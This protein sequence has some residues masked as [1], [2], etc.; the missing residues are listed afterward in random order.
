MSLEQDPLTNRPDTDT[1]IPHS[2]VHGNE[3]PVT[4]F[5]NTSLEDV[6]DQ[7]ML[8]TPTS[9]EAL[10]STWVERQP[11]RKGFTKKQK[12]IA[13]ISGAAL[14]LGIGA[15]LKSMNNS[16]E[17]VAPVGPVATAASGETAT[18]TAEATKTPEIIAPA[19]KFSPEALAELTPAQLTERFT[20]KADTIKT[21][22]QYLAAF[23]ERYNAQDNA[24]HTIADYGSY[25]NSGKGVYEAAMVEKYANSISLGMFD[26]TGI[27]N[28]TISYF[29]N[30]Y[31]LMSLLGRGGEYKVTDAEVKDSAEFTVRPDGFDIKVTITSRDTLRIKDIAGDTDGTNPTKNESILTIN[32]VHADNKGNLYPTEYKETQTVITPQHIENPTE[33][34]PIVPDK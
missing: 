20:I 31:S 8:T 26:N 7:G 28:G 19:G 2:G 13:G 4:E 32:N 15:G 17:Q 11:D 24:G 14:A 23:M 5:D 27:G 25:A 10:P 12:L 21:P 18:P 3:F 16:D 29:A 30:K 6:V 1:Q 9:A 22:D 33:A 34:Q